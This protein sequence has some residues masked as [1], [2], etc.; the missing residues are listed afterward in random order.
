MKRLIIIFS[1]LVSLISVVSA[2]DART[3]KFSFES[4]VDV[5]AKKTVTLTTPMVVILN[6]KK[7]LSKGK[8]KDIIF[9]ISNQNGKYNATW[10]S[11]LSAFLSREM[12]YDE[13]NTSFFFE[14]SKSDCT[15]L[16][17][18]D[19]DAVTLDIEDKTHNEHYYFTTKI[20]SLNEEN[21]RSLFKLEKVVSNN[22]IHSYEVISM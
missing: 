18:L 19:D 6:D 20:V 22:T 15:Y 4:L 11:N 7:D 3:Y 2:Q 10:A 8:E 14:N 5:K 16:L 21:K 9:K 13:S 17:L 1:V 12:Y